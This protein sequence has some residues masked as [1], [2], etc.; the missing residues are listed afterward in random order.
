M[1]NIFFLQR[2]HQ[3][4]HPPCFFFSLSLMM[5]F[6][7]AWYMA[8]V[9][10]GLSISAGIFSYMKIS[11][12]ICKWEINTK[13]I[14]CACLIVRTEKNSPSNKV[15][16]LQSPDNANEQIK[17][18]IK[19]KIFDETVSTVVSCDIKK[20]DL[21][22]WFLAISTGAVS[23]VSFSLHI[24]LHVWFPELQFFN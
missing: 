17:T 12:L 23:Q 18:N 10:F 1:V 5:C 14:G 13:I 7:N 6:F 2:W 4:W 3:Y 9:I 22:W 11:W 15:S 19:I 8:L 20:I 21:F 24:E 16:P